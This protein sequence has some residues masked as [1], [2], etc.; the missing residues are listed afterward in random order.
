MIE[1]CCIFNPTVP[2]NNYWED[3]NGVGPRKRNYTATADREVLRNKANVP[4]IT[5]HA[6]VKMKERKFVWK[7]C[8]INESIPNVYFLGNKRY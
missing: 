4:E 5:M 6:R 1:R 2:Q 3:T 8:M 7:E